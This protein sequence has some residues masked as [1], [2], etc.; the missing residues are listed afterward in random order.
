L[1]LSPGIS[2]SILPS[3]PSNYVYNFAEFPHIVGMGPTGGLPLGYTGI[4]KDKE[5]PIISYPVGTLIWGKDFASEY[6]LTETSGGRF[7][8]YNFV[9]YYDISRKTQYGLVQLSSDSMPSLLSLISGVGGNIEKVQEYQKWISS[10]L[11]DWFQN[12]I[13]D[14]NFSAQFVV[15]GKTDAI[16]CKGYKC[17][18]PAG[19]PGIQECPTTD[20]LCNCPCQGENTPFK[21]K[22]LSTY[23][24]EGQIIEDLPTPFMVLRPDLMD[25]EID[26]VSQTFVKIP[27]ENEGYEFGYEP[28]TLELEYLEKSINECELIQSTLGEDYLGCMYDDPNSNYNCICPKMGRKFMDYVKYNRT[29]STF[30][31][32]P[33]KTPLLRTAQM[34]LLNSNKITI[35][36]P[37]DLKVK[38]GQVIKIENNNARNKRFGG[39][40]LITTAKRYFNR[41]YHMME[42]TLSREGA[43]EA[44]ETGGE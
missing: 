3:D 9:H 32:T 41:A 6:E 1:G 17:M 34:A 40:W 29:Y 18:N 14:N 11:I 25:M 24:T 22:A 31:E 36:V 19:F 43:P 13:F 44:E 7:Y 12:T 33:L 4:R 21:G 16:G 30:W 2:A 39:R 5:Y 38:A 15:L 20:P 8:D 28:S 23:I 26:R 10:K 27:Q 37:G 42:L 35:T